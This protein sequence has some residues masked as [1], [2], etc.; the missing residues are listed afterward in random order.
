M[1]GSIIGPY[2]LLEPLGRGGMGVVY[3]ARHRDSG[4]IVALKT[5]HVL[6]EGQLQAIRREIAALAGLRHPGVVRIHEHGVEHGLPWYAMEFLQGRSLRHLISHGVVATDP[7]TDQCVLPGSDVG[8]WTATLEGEVSLGPRPP[9]APGPDVARRARLEPGELRVRLNLVRRLCEP[10]AFLHGE[11][12]VHRD[13][14]PENILIRAASGESRA[15]SNNKGHPAARSDRPA[16][17]GN[18][19]GSDLPA[20]RGSQLNTS[21]PPLAARSSKLPAPGSPVLVDFGLVSPFR[22]QLSRE[23]VFTALEAQGT[24]AYQAPEQARGE[25]V[26]ARADLYS[27]GCILYE[28]LAGRPPFLGENRFQVLWQHWEVEP[29]PPS[30]LVDGVSRELDELVLRLLTKHPRQRL[31]YAA[32]VAN[33]LELLGADG[34]HD[35]DGPPP[36]SYVYRPGFHG[37]QHELWELE[38][39]LQGLSAGGGGGLVLVSGESG[40][41]KTRLALELCAMARALGI[42]VLLGESRSEFGEM[43]GR[44]SSGGGALHTLN[45]PLRRIADRCRE[46]GLEETERLLGRRGPG[47][48]FYEPALRGLPGQERYGPPTELPPD[49]AR[50]RLYR[51][52]A[53]TF[54]ALASEKPLLLVLDDLQWADELTVGFVHLLCQTRSVEK[55]PWLVLGTYRSEEP[56]AAMEGLLAQSVLWKL[57]LGRLEEESVRTM[58]ADMLA[59]PLPPELFGAYLARHSEGNPFFVAEYVQAAVEEG[60]L[61]RDAQGRWQ[62]GQPG[63]EQASEASYEALA[64]PRSLRDLVKRRLEG[65]SA[66]ARQLVEAAAVVGREADVVVLGKMLERDVDALWEELRELE[67]RA[68]LLP[69]QDES[70]VADEPVAQAPASVRFAHDKIREVANAGLDGNGRRALH[71]AAAE[72]L[73]SHFGRDEHLAALGRHWEQA[74]Q[75]RKARKCFLGAARGALRQ[76]AL[77]EAEHLYRAYLSLAARPTPERVQARIELVQEVLHVGG[78][79]REAEA[80]GREALTEARKLEASGAE[81]RVLL[82]L[83][84]VAYDAGRKVE[85]G[86]LYERGLALARHAG[87]RAVEGM[88][89]SALASLALDQGR[90]EEAQGRYEAALDIHRQLADR[91]QEGIVLDKLGVLLAIRGDLT[92]ARSLHEQAL[93]IHRK[94]GNRREEGRALRNVAAVLTEQGH[95]DEALRLR[96]EVVAIHRETGNRLLE[97]QAIRNL[98]L[99]YHATS[100]LDEARSCYEQSL[101]IQREM[102]HRRVEGHTL[103][104]FGFLS[105][106]QGRLE[107]ARSQYAQALAILRQSGERRVEGRTLVSLADLELEEGELDSARMHLEQ[108]LERLRESGYGAME[109]EALTVMAGLQT[110]LGRPEEAARLYD[111]ALTIQRRSQAAWSEA[112]TLQRMATLM[113]RSAPDV[114]RAEALAAN[115]HTMFARQGDLFRQGLCLSELG[116]AALAKAL[117]A[118][119]Q[120]IEARDIISRCAVE[121]ASPLCKAVARLERAQAAFEAGQ[122]LFRG[123]LLEDIPEGLR[124]WLAETG[125]L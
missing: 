77:E 37:R 9:L 24:V 59:L 90:H 8:W 110:E 29:K 16:G 102:G 50:P 115:A 70:W 121:P 38:H 106:E 73:E 41:G 23:S 44:G 25:A 54:E 61:F 2:D 100:R 10:L 112:N 72:A 120:L 5:V 30:T 4:A 20:T 26:D 79:L 42:E 62:V 17:D 40:A 43:S 91:R 39:K 6:R 55:A 56:N 11:G 118:R 58:V 75:R 69:I 113:R 67:R 52:L 87:D 45:G 7:E 125:Q 47:L 123:E 76:H 85:A 80:E 60:L 71:R 14:K 88:A 116:H 33:A 95:H 53:E 32:D 51:F 82:V 34:S 18:E 31:G 103:S 15:A 89:Q 19:G 35:P 36:R 63:E 12:L 124:R 3:R 83:G 22:G 107:E 99:G 119:P 64:L 111:Q 98:G 101:A 84:D 46:R 97:A 66:Q 68:I 105:F 108:A 21:G 48:A 96:V 117:S 122:P 78:Q 114:A 13:L 28:L 49:A 74:G 81:L 104:Y 109:G 86:E 92:Q 27:L 94:L 1:Q 65:L 93:A 57:E